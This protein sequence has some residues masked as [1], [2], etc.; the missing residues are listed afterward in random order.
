MVAGTAQCLSLLLSKVRLAGELYWMSAVY[1]LAG[2]GCHTCKATDHFKLKTSHR[3]RTFCTPTK[4]FWPFS[5]AAKSTSA[6]SAREAKSKLAQLVGKKYGHD[7]SDSQKQGVREVLKELEAL[8]TGDMRQKELVGNW[9]LIY[10]ESTGSSGGKI[11]P[12]VGQVDQAIQ[13]L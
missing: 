2:S 4:A 13:I 3:S 9:K 1:P 11:G 7:L 5:Q 8:E 12:L 10:T 6:A